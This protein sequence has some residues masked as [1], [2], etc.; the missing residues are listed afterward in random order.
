MTGRDVLV[1]GGA[2]A[3]GSRLV[4]RLAGQGARIV[5]LDDLSSGYRENVPVEADFV[6]GSV[7][8]ADLVRRVFADRGG[9]DWVFHL[10]ALFANQNSV[11]HPVQ[12]LLVNTLGTLH[13]CE[14]ARETPT[15]LKRI[16]YTSS[17]CVYGNCTGAV[18]ETAPHHAETP[19]AIS[20]DTGERYLEYFSRHYG[21]PVTIVRL[22]NSFGP[23]ERPGRYRNVIPNFV[24][25]ALRNE[26]LTITGTGQETRD[27][28][29]VEDVIDGVIAA[30]L[31]G[32]ALGHT[33]NLGTGRETTIEVIAREIIRLSGSRS[34][35]VYVPP[36]SWDHVSRRCA[37]IGRAKA[38]FGFSPA[39][40]L[41]EGLSR[42]IDWLRTVSLTE[43][44]PA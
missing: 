15:K 9:F 30:A 21:L 8:D 37:N 3:L 43:A 25:L 32:A 41:P 27:F 40:P 38:D 33:Y 34:E 20:K 17:S 26:P 16:L 12:D 14:A 5:V 28:T 7:T 2:G 24:R 1:T 11:D 18:A 35:V 13:L 31:S 6:Q 19:Y 4:R 22:F 44:G 23:G 36:R 39:T 29:F 42:T 10:A